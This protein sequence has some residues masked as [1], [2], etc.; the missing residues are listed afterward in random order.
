MGAG[1]SMQYCWAGF[2][3]LKFNSIIFLRV[4]ISKQ[5]GCSVSLSSYLSMLLTPMKYREG[6]FPQ[7]QLGLT[8]SPF[9]HLPPLSLCGFVVCWGLNSWTYH[10]RFM[11]FTWLR[12]QHLVFAPIYSPSL[13]LEGNYQWSDFKIL[14]DF[15]ITLTS[16]LCWPA[17]ATMKLHN[18]LPNSGLFNIKLLFSCSMSVGQWWRV[19]AC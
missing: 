4:Y 16:N 15:F 1:S 8:W 17:A 19:C 14:I 9:I 5:R 6:H 13:V 2:S 11:L 18:S 10:S 7:I 3:P 12:P